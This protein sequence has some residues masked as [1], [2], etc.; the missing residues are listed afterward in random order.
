MNNLEGKTALL[1]RR[2]STTDQKLFGNSLNTQR[3]AL[4]DFCNSHQIVIKQELEE[5][6]SAK[7]FNRPVMQE[8]LSY[9]K[10]N[11]KEIDFVLI[12]NWD[13][14]SRNLLDALNVIRD[15]HAYGIMANSIEN[16][17]NYDDPTQMLLQVVQLA[18]PEIDDQ[19][20][21]KKVREGMRQGLKDADGICM[22]LLDM[23]KGEMN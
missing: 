6:F 3:D 4:R 19:V 8:L 13:R 7:N 9:A 12:T 1:Y 18:M 14:F 22:N 10:G 16:W 20:K 2:V 21:G 23:L 17:R 5:D 15:L 11:H